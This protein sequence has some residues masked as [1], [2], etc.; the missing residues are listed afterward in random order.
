MLSYGFL[1]ISLKPSIIKYVYLSI[2]SFLQIVL[3][4]FAAQSRNEIVF[5][6]IANENYPVFLGS[7][8]KALPLKGKLNL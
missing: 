8:E 4:S 6:D 2:F 7:Q 5:A 3:P 1:L